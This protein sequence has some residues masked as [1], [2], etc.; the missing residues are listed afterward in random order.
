MKPSISDPI[1]TTESSEVTVI[2]QTSMPQPTVSSTTGDDSSNGVSGDNM[3]RSS[4]SGQRISTTPSF[5]ETSNP[6]T[7]LTNSLD[8]KFIALIVMVAVLFLLATIG[9]FL[10]ILLFFLLLL[11]WGCIN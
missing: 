10:L 1:S 11:D 9:R 3:V 7:P 8:G 5:P 4:N 6:F 2:R